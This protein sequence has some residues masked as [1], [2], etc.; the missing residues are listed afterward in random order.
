[1][2]DY[3]V[4]RSSFTRG[5][6]TRASSLEVMSVADLAAKITEITKVADYEVAQV[7]AHAIG[8][9]ANLVTGAENVRRQ[10]TYSG[11]GNEI[12][13]DAQSKMLQVTGQN[14][15]ILVNAAQQEILQQAALAMR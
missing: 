2:S 10:L 4:P 14:L 12:F 3:L 1:M 5:S 8:T 7:G 9:M 11:Y 15:I 13:N 6:L